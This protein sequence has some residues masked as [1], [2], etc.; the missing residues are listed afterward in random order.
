MSDPIDDFLEYEKTAQLGSF[1]RGVGRGFRTL[2]RTVGQ[3]KGAPRMAGEAFEAF[4]RGGELGQKLQGGAALAAGGMA[5]AG[6]GAAAK[7]I[8]DAIH[9]RRT[10]KEMMSLNPD[11]AEVRDRDAPFFNAA[12]TS[13]RSVNPTFARDPITAGAMMVKMLD[14]P[15]HAGNV[16]LGSVRQ[17]T[18]DPPGGLGLGVEVPFGPM[19]FQKNF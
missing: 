14:N 12:Y 19:R 9:K 13:L 2:G 7:K 3:G 6:I 8:N 16:L 10:Y 17:P 5:L 1:L 18:A 11:L 15:E 4:S